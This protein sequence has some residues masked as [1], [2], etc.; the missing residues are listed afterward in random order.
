MS[1]EDVKAEIRKM[2]D[3][4]HPFMGK[5]SPSEVKAAR[6]RMVELQGKLHGDKVVVHGGGRAVM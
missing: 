1:P 5:G 6:E 4:D 2:Y 3:K